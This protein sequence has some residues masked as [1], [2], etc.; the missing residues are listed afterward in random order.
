MWM[1]FWTNIQL[2]KE[3]LDSSLNVKWYICVFTSD[4][5]PILSSITNQ[6]QIEVITSHFLQIIR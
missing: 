3:H 5:E 6:I 4:F 2:I 1:K